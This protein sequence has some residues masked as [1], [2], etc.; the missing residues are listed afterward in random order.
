[1][2]SSIPGAV[3]T[4]AYFLVALRYIHQNPGKAGIT[5]DN[6]TYLWSSYREYIGTPIVTDVDFGL[7]TFSRDRVKAISARP[8]A[9]TASPAS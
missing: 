4:D 9:K 7:D 5:R 3:E 2:W 6:S 1:M 8:S